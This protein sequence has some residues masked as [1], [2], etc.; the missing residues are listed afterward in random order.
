MAAFFSSMSLLLTSI[1]DVLSKIFN[2]YTG[3]IVLTGVLALWLLRKVA[4]LFGKL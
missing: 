1:F 4:K 3:Q 2:V